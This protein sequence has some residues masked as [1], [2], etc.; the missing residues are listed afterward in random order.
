MPTIEQCTCNTE[1]PSEKE[2]F[3]PK[4]GHVTQNQEKKV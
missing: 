3:G 2:G 4:S 1:K